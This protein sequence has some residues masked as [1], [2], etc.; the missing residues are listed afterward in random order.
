MRSVLLLTN[1]RSGVGLGSRTAAAA[2]ERFAARGVTVT[3]VC[4]TS[5][6][7]SARLVRAA[8]TGADRPDV[9]VVAGGD[10]LVN[11]ALD[12]LADTGV[13]LGLVPSG[14]GNDLARYFDIPRADPAAAADVVLDGEN[15]TIDLGMVEREG[16]ARRFATV[17]ATG[18]DARVTLRANRMTFP[19]GSLRYTAAAALELFGRMVLPYRMEFADGT[20]LETDAV[21]VAVGNTSTYG[22][23]MPICPDAVP[24]DGLLDVTVVGRISRPTMAVLLPRVASG[25]FIAHPA[26]SR[27]RVTG[28]TLAAEAPVTAD[29][30]DFGTLPV[31]IRVLPGAQQIRV[32]RA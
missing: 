29:G 11:L 4:G 14:T 5:A 13:P 25:H 26:V 16:S 32:P 6:D 30:E 28:L 27:H 23:G 7:E 18:L 10:G 19:R 3:E 31:T 12:A 1:P 15:R 17:A 2:F 21:M 20:V 8:V 24:D 22:G 9:V